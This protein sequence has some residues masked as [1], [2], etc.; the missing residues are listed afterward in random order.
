MFI[1]SVRLCSLIGDAI[2]SMLN[3]KRLSRSLC[4]GLEVLAA[5]TDRYFCPNGYARV[6]S[7]QLQHAGE[8]K[9][10][11]LNGKVTVSG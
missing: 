7:E 6:F 4:C 1:G 9:D 11:D 8:L 2:P 3:R 5:S 10:F